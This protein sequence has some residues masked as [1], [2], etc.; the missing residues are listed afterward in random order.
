MVH[1]DHNPRLFICM[2]QIKDL[3]SWK[4][5]LHLESSAAAWEGKDWREREEEGVRKR[6]RVVI[7]T[8]LAPSFPQRK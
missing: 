4:Q 1:C 7:P 5:R 6:G 3:V 2:L 8:S